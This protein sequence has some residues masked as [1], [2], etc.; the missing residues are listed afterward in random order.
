MADGRLFA[1]VL[2]GVD[3]ADGCRETVT[4]A[5]AIVDPAGSVTFAANVDDL[6]ER[7]AH[8]DLLIVPAHEHSRF[9]AIL[10][11][12]TPAVA[13]HAA[14]V[15]VLVTRQLPDVAF[16]GTVVAA[17]AGGGDAETV[18]VAARIAAAHRRRLILGHAGRL[19]G[20][21]ADAV[22]HQATAASSVTGQPS[23]VLAGPGDPAARMVAIAENASAGLIVTG[24]SGRRGVR[25][26]ASMSERIAH[27]AR[28]SVLVLRSFPQR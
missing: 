26:L 28:C 19:D 3:E 1:R 18:N 2:C 17:T 25:A 15:P 9:A 24:S 10:L 8:F 12:S 21:A 6:L 7:A 22:S 27:R 20:A 13:V 4:Q 14:P 5:L 23:T 11:G 16:P